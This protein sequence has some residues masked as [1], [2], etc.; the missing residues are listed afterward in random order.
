MTS[1]ADPA[2]N[3]ASASG[4]AAASE[5]AR[6]GVDALIAAVAAADSATSAAA[7]QS[8]ECAAPK[9]ATPERQVA[10]FGASAVAFA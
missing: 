6:A 8:T 10:T 7:V 9:H 5:T 4:P 3:P 2:P 1:L